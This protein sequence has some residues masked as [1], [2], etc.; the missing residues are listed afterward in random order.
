[1]LNLNT[2]DDLDFKGAAVYKIVV[3]GEVSGE[4]MKRRWRLQVS[5]LKSR[6][7][8]PITSIVGQINDQTSLAGILNMLFNMHMTVISVNMLTE[9]GKQS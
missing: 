7:R 8:K 5:Q 2:T 3:Q 1:M 9:M 4:L 6:N